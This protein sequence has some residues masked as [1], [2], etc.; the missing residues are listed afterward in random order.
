MKLQRWQQLEGNDQTLTFSH[1]EI[2]RVSG[3]VSAIKVYTIRAKTMTLHRRQ[4]NTPIVSIFFWCRSVRQAIYFCHREM[5]KSKFSF[6]F[7]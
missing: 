6:H 2:V 3:D 1:V 7:R 4:E 5:E